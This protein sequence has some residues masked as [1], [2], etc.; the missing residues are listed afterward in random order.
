MYHLEWTP[1]FI[2][3]AKRFAK[4]HPELKQKTAI[5]LLAL[6]QDPFQASLKLHGLG[7]KLK[8]LHAVR[9]TYSYR[10]TLMLKISEHVITLLD[11]GDHDDVY[12]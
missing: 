7:G 9:I 2:K 5:A 3:A 12:R 4:R 11:I 8:G 1:A 6:E 10:I